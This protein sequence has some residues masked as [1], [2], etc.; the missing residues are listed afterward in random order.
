MAERYESFVELTSF[1]DVNVPYLVPLSCVI[2]FT[3]EWD[4]FDS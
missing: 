3:A 4:H 2:P 1:L